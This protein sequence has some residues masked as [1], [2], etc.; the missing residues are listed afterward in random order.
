[1]FDLPEAKR[2]AA[3]LVTTSIDYL[4]IIRSVRRDEV[5]SP[6]SSRSPSPVDES[7]LQDAHARLGKL[8]NLDGLLEASTTSKIAEDTPEQAGGEED[9]EQE[10]EF[11]LF[12]A[13]STLN[14]TGKEA[15]ETN[16]KAKDTPGS[17]TLVYTGTQKLRIRLRSPTPGSGD[18]SE[19]RF[20]RASRGW[21]YYFSTPLLWGSGVELGDQSSQS[22]MRRQ[23]EDMAVTGE[24]IITW[25]KS[26]P[27][28][29]QIAYSIPW[30]STNIS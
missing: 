23:F 7:D 19:G 5:R 27:W 3:S 9:D 1:M 16:K 15:G 14:S 26:Q 25:A 8:L 11:R 12:S 20:V 10:F 21:Q 29:S 24:Q 2:Y 28:V 30:S 22:E 13:P 17:E 18:P 6:A 4:L